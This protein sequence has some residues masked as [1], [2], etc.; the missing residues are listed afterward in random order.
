MTNETRP[1]LGLTPRFIEEEYRMADIMD[2]MARYSRAGK[3][4]PEE[5]V[6]EA[7]ELYDRKRSS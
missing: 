1:V 3:A 6:T 2:A 7:V 4:I 5:W